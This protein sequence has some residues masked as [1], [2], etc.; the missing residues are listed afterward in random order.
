MGDMEDVSELQKL[1]DKVKALER[2]NAM[3]KQNQPVDS[4]DEAAFTKVGDR[5]KMRVNS[6]DCD[7]LEDVKLIDIESLEGSEGDW[8]VSMDK[9]EADEVDN[10]DWLR[11]D[12]ESPSAIVAIKKKSLVNRLED[13][14]RGDYLH[15]FLRRGRKFQ[16]CV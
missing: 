12:I 13:L 16:I 5:S 8:L 7:Q 1:Q 9:E 10:L 11:K 2:Q 4:V 3:L 15:S 6:N 14:A